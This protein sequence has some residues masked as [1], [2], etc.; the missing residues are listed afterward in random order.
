MHYLPCFEGA[1]APFNI[2]EYDVVTGTHLTLRAA[3]F[4]TIC[5]D[6]AGQRSQC[7]CYPVFCGRK[8]RCPDGE[9]RSLHQ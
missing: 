7:Y 9:E 3:D 6:E 8:V 5:V 2:E 4:D 1:P